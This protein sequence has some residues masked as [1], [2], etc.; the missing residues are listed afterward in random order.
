MECVGGAWWELQVADGWS[1]SHDAECLTLTR[2][3]S[4][5]F[6]LSAAVKSLGSILSSEVEGQSR[7]G[8]PVGVKS[9]PYTAGK[10]TGS[11]VGYE[12][13]DAHWQ[14]FWLACANILVFAT[15]NGSHEAWLSEQSAVYAMLASLKPRAAADVLPA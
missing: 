4:G 14:K 11:T 15:Y 6:Q 1:A 13:E 3:N 8:T 10:F 12:E 5:A 9:F 7:Q 2:T